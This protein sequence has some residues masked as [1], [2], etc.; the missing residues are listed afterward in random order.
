MQIRFK[1]RILGIFELSPSSPKNE[2]KGADGLRGGRG[3]CFS[4]TEG[5][6]G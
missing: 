1:D 2:E 3:C 5:G 6:L 4:E